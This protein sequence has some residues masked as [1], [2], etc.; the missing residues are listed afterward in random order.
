MSSF[1][2]KSRAAFYDPLQ[3]KDACLWRRAKELVG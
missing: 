2:N 3:H 1:E